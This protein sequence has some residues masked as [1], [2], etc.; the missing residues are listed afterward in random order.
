VRYRL[1]SGNLPGRRFLEPGR[2]SVDS[3]QGSLE[4]R[5]G[6]LK[7]VRRR[8]CSTLSAAT[9]P[10]RSSIPC[11]SAVQSG[12]GGVD[13][14]S[15]APAGARPRISGPHGGLRRPSCPRPG[16]REWLECWEVAGWTRWCEEVVWGEAPE[17]SH[18][19]GRLVVANLEREEL[20]DALLSQGI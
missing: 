19:L 13:Q 7:L 12:G 4:L 20:A 5:R 2:G 6:F 14:L 10:E 16:R 8:S 1:G 15:L 9:W 11:R 17:M 18:K 3:E